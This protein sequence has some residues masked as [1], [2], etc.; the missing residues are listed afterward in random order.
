VAHMQYDKTSVHHM[1]VM[2][3]SG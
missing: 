1:L 2:C 3:Y